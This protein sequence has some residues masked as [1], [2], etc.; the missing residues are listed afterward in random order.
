MGL[1]VSVLGLLQ[2]INGFLRPK[3]GGRVAGAVPSPRRRAWQV[4]HKVSVGIS[5]P[6]SHPKHKHKHKP[7]PKPNPSP[8]PTQATRRQCTRASSARGELH[9]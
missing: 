6:T 2:L 7:K 3:K 1:L 9:F 4:F 8:S 5:N